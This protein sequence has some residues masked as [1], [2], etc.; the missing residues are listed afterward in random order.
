LIS[1]VKCKLP[2]IF[3]QARLA[4][5]SV[6]IQAQLDEERKSTV[7]HGGRAAQQLVALRAELNQLN[8]Q[9]EQ[10]IGLRVK[11]DHDCLAAKKQAEEQKKADHAQLQKWQRQL[12]VSEETARKTKE[13]LDLLR[14]R[15]V[16]APVQPTPVK[17]TGPLPKFP[18][19]SKAALK[20]PERDATRKRDGTA[21]PLSPAPSATKRARFAATKAVPSPDDHENVSS[22]ELVTSSLP[23]AQ[24]PAKDT[25]LQNKFAGSAQ[26]LHLSTVPQS[27]DRLDAAVCGR[28]RVERE[29]LTCLFAADAGDGHGL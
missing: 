3:E 8:Q 25:V 22:P 2:L 11:A 9:L 19:S 21:P 23:R 1:P 13:Q 7:E 20:L 29:R 28:E 15:P 18:T 14:A 17:N 6:A 16:L 27:R 24:S 5:A 10:N 26:P 4:E 12:A